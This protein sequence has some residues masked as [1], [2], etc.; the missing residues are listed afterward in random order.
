MSEADGAVALVVE[1]RPRTVGNS[2]VSRSLPSM[3]RRMVGPFVFLDHMGPVALQPGH[4]FD[5][6][7]HPHI[8][9]STLTYLFEGD[10]LH[11]DSLGNVQVIRPGDV[12][13]MTAGRGVVHSE[14]STDES[15]AR[16]GAQHGLQLWIALP[17]ADEIGR[18]SFAHVPRAE[19]PQRDSDGA[20]V[21]VVLGTA[22]GLASSLRHPSHPLFAD[23]ILTESGSLRT[24]EGLPECAI[25]VASGRVRIGARTVG[26]KTL[27]VLEAGAVVDLVA[28][29]ASRVVVLG[30]PSIGKRF[31]DWNFVSSSEERIE[32]AK[33]D[34]RL[35]RFPSIPGDDVEFEPLPEPRRHP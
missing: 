10:G 31:I 34:W 27:A 15:R 18:P 23:A 30:G 16:G 3:A 21:T 7:P 1:G 9:L 24:P 12:N 25:Y 33:Q 28:A 19:L 8:G 20:K 11:R 6:K 29:E 5:V 4:G 32:Q 17:E 35:R 22:W 14:R 26:P 2:Q 13:L